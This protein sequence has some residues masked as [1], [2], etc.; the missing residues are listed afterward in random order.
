[1]QARKLFSC[2]R[3]TRVCCTNLLSLTITFI[4]RIGTFD[5]FC[6]HG[7]YF[8]WNI[9]DYSKVNDHIDTRE[10]NFL[11]NP[12]SWAGGERNSPHD[13][14]P[15]LS[16]ATT[17]LML[18]EDS[19]KVF[20]YNKVT[21]RSHDVSQNTWQI[22]SLFEHQRIDAF[23][24]TLLSTNE[25]VAAE[26]LLVNPQLVLK[27]GY[28]HTLENRWRQFRDG[29]LQDVGHFE[30]EAFEIYSLLGWCWEEAKQHS[31]SKTSASHSCYARGARAQ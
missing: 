3:V 20:I 24:A 23:V 9:M 18:D 13:I 12:K 22:D 7:R 29:N 10:C 1:M 26:L 17:A 14:P 16:V 19:K 4:R 28:T 30:R 6:C 15:F 5:T 2:L 21:N 8:S 27:N 11:S 31:A 25:T